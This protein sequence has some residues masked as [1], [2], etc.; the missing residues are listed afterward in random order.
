MNHLVSSAL[1]A[2]GGCTL[3]DRNQRMNGTIAVVV[4]DLYVAGNLVR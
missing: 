1:F 2:D 3:N 4:R